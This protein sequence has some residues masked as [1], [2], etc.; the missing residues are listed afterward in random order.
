MIL[1]SFD[2]IYETHK[3]L[4]F[5]LSLQYVQHQED[6]EEITQDVFVKVYQ[7]LDQFKED[8]TLTTWIYRITINTSLDFLKAKQR[9]KRWGILTSIFHDNQ[10][11]IKHD[12]INFSHPG[13]ELE[14]KEEVAKIFLAINSLAE[15]QKTAIILSKLEQ[16]TQQEIAEIMNLSTKAVESLIQRAKTNLQKK[17]K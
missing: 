1:L 17:L 8:S 16:K 4:V 11:E 3:Q 14:H 7:S 15:N 5:N 9:K 6:A 10:V 2:E 13:V 12:G